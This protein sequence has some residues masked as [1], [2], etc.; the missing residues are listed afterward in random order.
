[1]KRITETLIAV[2]LLGAVS[3]FAEEAPQEEEYMCKMSTLN[4]VLDGYNIS[5]KGVNTA[6]AYNPKTIKRTKDGVFVWISFVNTR[7]NTQAYSDNEGY[8]LSYIFMNKKER[9]YR[10][11]DAS[12]YACDGTIT[13]HYTKGESNVIFPKS[14]MEGL[15][16]EMFP[17]KGK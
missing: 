13:G 16:E 6:V 15:Y 5:S 2:A 17:V 1:M 7:N 8:V 3:L 14:I 9:T 11:I 12:G 10:A 4:K